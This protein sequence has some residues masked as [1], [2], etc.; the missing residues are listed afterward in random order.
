MWSIIKRWRP[1][2]VASQSVLGTVG[3]LSAV[4]LFVGALSLILAPRSGLPLSSFNTPAY[5]V[6]CNATV[7]QSCHVWFSTTI[8]QPEYY[9]A[10][11]DFL[12]KNTEDN[13]ITIHLTCYC[14]NTV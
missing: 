3:V 6:S 14:C 12:S 5:V 10:L 8:V 9:V 7:P 4:L 13:K 11:Y 1:N 2:S